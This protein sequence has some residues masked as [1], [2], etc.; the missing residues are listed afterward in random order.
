MRFELPYFTI[1][2]IQVRYLK[3]VEKTG[4]QA[5]PW[6][7]YITQNGDDYRWGL[8][9]IFASAWTLTSCCQSAKCRGKRRAA[10]W[11]DMSLWNR[12]TNCIE[13][14]PSSVLGIMLAGIM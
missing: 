3:V 7:R 9:G 14:H 8:R 10:S 5:L 4:Y 2:G 12:W 6:V 1:S 11:D 13:I